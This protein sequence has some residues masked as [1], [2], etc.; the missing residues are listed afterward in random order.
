[1]TVLVEPFASVYEANHVGERQAGR[2]QGGADAGAA[3]MSMPRGRPKTL[4]MGGA[5][6]HPQQRVFDDLLWDVMQTC[7]RHDLTTSVRQLVGWM[8]RDFPKYELVPY[9]TLRRDITAVMHWAASKLYRLRLLKD[10]VMLGFNEATGLFDEA[11]VDK[12]FAAA[13]ARPTKLNQD[14]FK[15]TLRRLCELL[16]QSPDGWPNTVA[17][18]VGPKK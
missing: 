10:D 13:Q 17:R 14:Q 1:M 6:P 12:A 7:L 5:V 16:I 2:R 4:H 15:K 3:V 8:Q 18:I 11:T 9:R